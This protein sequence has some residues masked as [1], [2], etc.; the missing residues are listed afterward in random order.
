MWKKTNYSLMIGIAI[1]LISCTFKLPY[2]Y[3]EITRFIVTAG[4]IWLTISFNGE[5]K[6]GWRFFFG[7]LAILFNPFY[8]LKIGAD[9]FKLLDV[10]V[11]VI[12]LW[13]LMKE[14]INFN[15]IKNKIKSCYNFF[16]KR[17]KVIVYSL[18]LVV[19]AFIITIGILKHKE[20]TEKYKVE[21]IEKLKQDSLKQVQFKQDSI[22]N[23]SRK[24]RDTQ[25]QLLK[26]KFCTK[27]EALRNF[28]DWMAFYHPQWKI[29][30]KINIISS[31]N[32][33]SDDC[34]YKIS[35]LVYN[36]EYEETG[37]LIVEINFE[38]DW[39]YSKYRIEIIE[40]PALF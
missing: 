5:E 18:I 27:N 20:E 26:D 34:S 13:F 19:L 7:T 14:T 36:A 15:V 30:S 32:D 6:L 8:K 37:T 29:R 2:E 11:T 9:L 10:L 38:S 33:F 3:Y 31:G 1:L 4:F 39:S 16:I 35:L 12:I 17:G 23:E 22:E 25:N 21:R 40:R 24:I 28:K